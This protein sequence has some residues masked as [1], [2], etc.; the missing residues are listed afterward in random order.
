MG[1]SQDPQEQVT[2]N[3]SAVFSL[4][5][6]SGGCVVY[7]VS[8]G[9]ITV[10]FS[11]FVTCSSPTV[12]KSC[13]RNLFKRCVPESWLRT[14]FKKCVQQTCLTNIFNRNLSQKSGKEM[15]SRRDMSNKSLMGEGA[16]PN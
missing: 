2:V 15:S 16:P 6:C 10:L 1:E 5:W 9:V 13:P 14:V 4:W 7:M 8:Y 3:V 11:Y 12:Q